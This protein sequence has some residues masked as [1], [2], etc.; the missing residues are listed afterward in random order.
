MA[1]QPF[2]RGIS[3]L[4]VRA[5][6]SQK[7][8]KKP[9]AVSPTLPSLDPYAADDGSE[10]FEPDFG[11]LFEVAVEPK[12]VPK[13]SARPPKGDQL[14]APIIRQHRLSAS[15]RIMR[16]KFQVT[17]LDRYEGGPTTG[18]GFSVMG[19]YYLP[20]YFSLQGAIDT[21]ATNTRYRSPG[22]DAPAERQN[23]VRAQ[24]GLKKDWLNTFAYH[25]NWSLALGF[26]QN[27]VQIPFE[28]DQQKLLEAGL[29]VYLENHQHKSRLEF[30]QFRS[31]SQELRLSQGLPW[32]LGPLNTQVGLFSYRTL[33]SSNATSAMFTESGL[34]FGLEY[35]F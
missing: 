28:Q 23:R 2:A 15:V 18:L 22:A 31:G 29:A 27:F 1:S 12:A 35:E 17:R 33:R 14:L 11:D 24:L 30:T 13:V 8:L 25:P 6:S 34:R 32:H 20:R 7:S 9:I 19:E 3:G 26:V 16:E 10:R 4:R 5:A 21:H